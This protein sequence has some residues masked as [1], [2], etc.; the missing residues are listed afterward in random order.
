MDL[1]FVAKVKSKIQ[2]GCANL[3]SNSIY[4]EQDKPDDAKIG[5]SVFFYPDLS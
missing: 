1:K 5:T 3:Y 2:E 4:E